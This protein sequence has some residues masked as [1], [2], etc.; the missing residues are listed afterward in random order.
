MRSSSGRYSPFLRPIHYVLDLAII[1]I[2]AQQFFLGQ[3]EY[4]SFGFYIVFSWLITTAG[5][6]F[7]EVYRFTPLLKILY[8]LGKQLIL[9][10]VL[11]FSF[12]GIFNEINR[13]IEN[14]F[15]YILLCFAGIAVVKIGIF[16]LLK[17]YRTIL[18]GNFRRVVI[19]GKNSKTLRLK[20]FFTKNP[21]YGYELV[22]IFDFRKNENQLQEAIAY[23]IKHEIDEI[24]CSIAELK[25]KELAEIVDFADN[26]LIIVKF[27][28]DNREIFSTKLKYQYYGITPIL[29]LRTMPIE[30][31]FNQ[32]SKRMLDIII[33]LIVVL[34]LLVW[35]TPIL[36]ILIKLESKGPV[37]F[38]QR[39]NGLDY[40][41]FYCYKFRS[42]RLNAKADLEQVSKNDKR[43]TIIG[44]FL[45]KTSIDELPQFI[46]VLLGE[47]SVVG[48]RPH[49]VSHT[50]MYAAKIDKFMVRH[51][52][53]PGITGLAQVSGYRGEVE[54]ENDIKNRVRFDIFY[55]ENWSILMDLRIMAKT[56]LNTIKGDEKAY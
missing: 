31:S 55:L 35:I 10:T 23:I 5:I 9:F 24:Y 26:N 44:K 40:K 8:L 16:N 39:R 45:R 27:L 1:L 49:M 12:Y 19:L 13:E 37:F 34:G 47:M 17:K 46:N 41:E 7:Y 53:K 3:T 50:H 18:G 4:W 32:F 25:N 14:V 21:A 36:A 2:L 30:N 43:I 42:M 33:S 6:G 38:K 15:R 48:P 22:K 20:T 52:V 28:P 54:S 51:F 11:V 29:S 56:I